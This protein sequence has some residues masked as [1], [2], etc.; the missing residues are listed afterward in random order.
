MR[1]VHQLGLVSTIRLS[2]DV[3]LE[4]GQ[5]TA[6]I[7]FIAAFV[8]PV[9][10]LRFLVSWQQ[11]KQNLVFI[12]ISILACTIPYLLAQVNYEFPALVG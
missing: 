9:L 8:I 6:F 2:E 5:K 1:L 4:V 12:Y 11:I 10:A 7:H 3:V